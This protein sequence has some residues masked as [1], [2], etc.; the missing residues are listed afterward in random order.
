[1]T[2]RGKEPS[3]GD[4]GVSA[5]LGLPLAPEARPR[6][7][8]L[9]PS[10][11]SNLAQ[12][13]SLAGSDLPKTVSITSST[14]QTGR[15]SIG[16]LVG[17]PLPWTKGTRLLSKRE[18]LRFARGNQVP[19]LVLRPVRDDEEATTELAADNRITVKLADRLHLGLAADG[20]SVLAVVRDHLPNVLYLLGERSLGAILAEGWTDA[21]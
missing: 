16:L 20:D 11:T 10:A 14:T 21:R 13:V 5:A 1:M 9:R 19:A 7:P 3:K 8:H 18:L 6:V 4:L 17:S 2:T 12:S 15:V